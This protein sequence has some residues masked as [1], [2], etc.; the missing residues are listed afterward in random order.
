MGHYETQRHHGALE[1]DMAL[2]G[3]GKKHAECARLKRT[4]IE[5]EHPPHRSRA[6]GR[7]TGHPDTDTQPPSP[8]DPSQPRS[9]P[10]GVK[11]RPCQVAP[12]K[13]LRGGSR[14]RPTN[15]L[16][17]G[18]RR[19]R[20]EAARPPRQGQAPRPAHTPQEAAALPCLAALLPATPQLPHPGGGELRRPPGSARQGSRERPLARLQQTH[21]QLAALPLGRCP[22]PP[23]P[24]RLPPASPTRAAPAARPALTARAPTWPP[25]RGQ[26]G[27]GNSSPTST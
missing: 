9:R 10:L 18:S 19:R 12:M 25:R 17:S 23:S 16:C 27:R 5:A 2:L 24:P 15:T 1:K 13:G 14:P 22:I 26:R 6:P 11:C 20:P 8:A 4:K 7:S 21:G 3:P